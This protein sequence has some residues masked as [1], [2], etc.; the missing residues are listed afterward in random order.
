L[1]ESSE[2][3]WGNRQSKGFQFLMTPSFYASKNKE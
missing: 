2:C 1:L 3:T